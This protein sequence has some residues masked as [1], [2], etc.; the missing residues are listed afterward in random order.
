MESTQVSF[1]DLIAE[2]RKQSMVSRLNGDK[3]LTSRLDKNFYSFK[4]LI[5][6][7]NLLPYMFEELH[8]LKIN[9]ADMNHSF[10]D[11]L[12]KY[13]SPYT[14]TKNIRNRGKGDKL[15]IIDPV[16]L[17]VMRCTRSLLRD[18]M[19]LS[20]T[21]NF[22][23][24]TQEQAIVDMIKYFTILSFREFPIT[25]F[26]QQSD[27]GYGVHLIVPEG[28]FYDQ[29][30][31]NLIIEFL[32]RKFND[33]EL[34]VELDAMF[35]SMKQI[36]LYE[37]A[38]DVKSI[39]INDK[40]IDQEM[41]FKMMDNEPLKKSIFTDLDSM[42][43]NKVVFALEKHCGSKW[44]SR[45]LLDLRDSMQRHHLI[46]KPVEKM[47]RRSRSVVDEFKNLS[48]ILEDTDTVAS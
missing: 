42:C 48:V 17:A 15:R 43:Y 10:I 12:Y 38:E 23:G 37:L 1:G 32:S 14:A 26:D 16:A 25:K 3:T 19:T 4:D 21:L 40:E 31:R 22:Y 30:L 7:S 11:I 29:L 13:L 20:R 27:R 8:M 33:S 47:Y 28:S 45:V 6:M 5:E 35:R 2:N 18:D 41:Y 39:L 44:I 34:H 46:L 24:G 9:K 36:I